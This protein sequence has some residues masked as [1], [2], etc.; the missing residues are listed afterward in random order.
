MDILTFSIKINQN[1]MQE[2][3]QQKTK[4]KIRSTLSM[5]RFAD[6]GYYHRLL[7]ALQDLRREEDKLYILQKNR[8]DMITAAKN[9]IEVPEGYYEVLG[10][11]IAELRGENLQTE[12]KTQR[13]EDK[14]KEK[15]AEESEQ[16]SKEGTED[17]A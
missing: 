11:I 8:E 4:R 9:G 17:I 2:A 5:D 16:S 7:F 14:S 3:K 1:R 10:E 15:A 6:H 13:N 12:N